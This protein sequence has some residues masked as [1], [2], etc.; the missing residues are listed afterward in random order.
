MKFVRLDSGN[1]V[2]VSLIA[3]IQKNW[4]HSWEAEGSGDKKRIHRITALGNT[5]S[6]SDD[7]ILKIIEAIEATEGLL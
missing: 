4:C 2:N 3:T 5:L 7:D 1:L 6:A